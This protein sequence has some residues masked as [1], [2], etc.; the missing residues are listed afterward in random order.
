MGIDYRGAHIFV[1]EQFLDGTDV[2]SILEQV[3]SET[4][5]ERM[6]AHRLIDCRQVQ[7]FFY[8]LL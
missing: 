6:A 5:P 1:S 3:R 4:V 2:I 8:R 7:G